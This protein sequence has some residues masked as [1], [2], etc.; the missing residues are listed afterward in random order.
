MHGLHQSTSLVGIPHLLSILANDKKTV[1]LNSSLLF[2]FLQNKF[3]KNST[4]GV[5][6]GKCPL[7]CIY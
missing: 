1:S 3:K 2:F 7:H 5:C 6:V 4:S